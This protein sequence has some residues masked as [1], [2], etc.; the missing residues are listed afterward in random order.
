MDYRDSNYDIYAQR[1]SK[2]RIPLGPNFKVNDDS[3]RVSQGSPSISVDSN[4]NFVITWEDKRNGNDDIYS[5]RYSSDGSVLGPN[6]IVNDDQG[7]ALQ[8]NPSVCTVANGNFIITWGDRR[9]YSNIYAQVYSSYGL[10]IGPNFKVNDSLGNTQ[11]PSISADISG[12][13]VIT[14]E[15]GRN[16]HVDIYAQRYYSDGSVLG[17]NFKVNDDEGSVDQVLPSIS[18]DGDGNFVITW[19]D[20]RNGDF[21]IYAQRFSS[22]GTASGINFRA[23][24]DKGNYDQRAPSVSTD[25]N[26]NYII[27]WS[28]RYAILA[29]SY[30]SDGNLLGFNF[31]V[32]DLSANNNPSNP[33]ISSDSNGNFV[34][35]WVDD[36]YIDRDIYAQCYSSDGSKVETN[37]IV[38]DDQGC[39]NQWYPIISVDGSGNFVIVWQDERNRG[40]SDIYAQRFS[41]DGIAL[42]NNFRVNDDQTFD[43]QGAPSISS[44]K[45]GNFV[46]TWEDYRDVGSNIYAQRYSIDGSALGTNFM[47]NI[48][49]AGVGS[50]TPSIGSDG[51]GNFVITWWRNDYRNEIN[52]IYAQRYSS[53][54]TALGT[55]FKVNDNLSNV[56]IW[57]SPSMHINYSGNF[58][59]L[60]TDYRN[61]DSDI[62]AQRYSS[63]GIALGANF[64][65][66]DDKGGI[67]K[68]AG[69]VSIDN[70]GNFVITWTDWRNG[71]SDIYAQRYSNNGTTLESNFRVN[72]DQ[73]SISQGGSSISTDDNGNFVITWTDQRNGDRD[74]YAQRFSSDGNPVGSNFRITNTS[75]EVQFW[76]DVKFWNNRIYTT[77]NDNRAEGTGY[78]IWANVLDRNTVGIAEESDLV[79]AEIVLYQN[80]PNPFSPGGGTAYG[81]NSSTN[82]QFTINKSQNVTLKIYNLRGEEVVT[83]LNQHLPAGALNVSWNASG[84]ESGLYFYKLQAGQ[85]I[86]TKKLLLIK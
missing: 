3:G 9:N 5:Q 57:S 86:E 56:K 73:E 45:A 29:Q 77:W 46:I 38:N 76:A 64:K 80:Y 68:S 70:S 44:D 58:I 69:S 39:S 2:N 61:G 52:D 74:I 72:D 33:S 81:G 26:G 30:T 6:F 54:G 55:N 41:N 14:W 15:D 7:S 43:S 78:D 84:F 10:A 82:I 79:P 21:D 11:Y 18:V 1:Y 63:N 67:R 51:I 36:R 50:R 25:R 22:D 34:I 75:E 20:K 85:H 32:N 60:W 47:V 19:M 49:E 28:D 35:V 4:G 27:T 16:G 8:F 17:M 83:L 59:I 40:F 24:N 23:N 37:F 13:F 31:I 12:N 65:V 62:Y 48:D 71:D 66:N 53:D 42:G